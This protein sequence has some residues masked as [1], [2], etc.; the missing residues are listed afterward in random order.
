MCF[1]SFGE[2]FGFSMFKIHV[3]EFQLIVSSKQPIVFPLTPLYNA[4]M[5][6]YA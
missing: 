4:A 6:A 3:I 1:S 5:F 2:G